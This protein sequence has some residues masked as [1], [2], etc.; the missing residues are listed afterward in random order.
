MNVD[1]MKVYMRTIKSH[2]DS[3][4]YFSR[5]VTN[6]IYEIEEK[7]MDVEDGIC[8]FKENDINGRI[9]LLEGAASRMYSLGDSPA[10]LNSSRCS[11]D[12]I[13]ADGFY[14]SEFYLK[15]IV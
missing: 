12:H 8:E 3:L 1:E 10:R 7:L 4:N 15:K 13:A 6:M 2:V 14:Q 5:Q 11:K 9:Q